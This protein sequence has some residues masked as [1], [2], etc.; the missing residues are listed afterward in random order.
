M[1]KKTKYIKS[2]VISIVITCMLMAAY[3]AFVLGYTW[4]YVAHSTLS[5]GRN[6]PL[7]AY[8]HTLASAVVAFTLNKQAVE[9]VT[10]AMESKGTPSNLMDKHNNYIGA[11]IGS[12]AHTFSEIEATVFLKIMNGKE[13]ASSIEQT[14]WL[15]KNFWYNSWL[16]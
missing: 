1:Q 14:T 2:L 8:R 4:Y 9:L 3:P 12:N 13:Y 5:G 16:W 6:G 11:V 7:D 10:N 15:A